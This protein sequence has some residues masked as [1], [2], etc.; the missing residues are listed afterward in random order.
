MS[1]LPLVLAAYFLGAVPTSHLVAG[2]LFG[3]D[4]RTRGSGNLGAT[5]VVRVLGWRAGLP[6]G[7]FDAFKGWLPVAAFP[8]LHGGAAWEWALAYAAAAILGHVFPVWTGFRGGKG[9]AT[10]AGAMLALAPWALLAGAVVWVALAFAVR[11][12][13]VASMAGALAVPVAV[14]LT[15]AG[16][17]RDALVAFTGGLAL[18]VLWAHRANIARLLT[19][20]EHRFGREKPAGSEE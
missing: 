10:A 3:T 20:E 8:H 15:V 4:L 17:H 5:N 6:V 1:P 14:W 13:S 7:L 16:P 12:V 11:I 19:G 9:V 18:F 2:G